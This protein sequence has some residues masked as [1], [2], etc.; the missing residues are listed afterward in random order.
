[1]K[2]ILLLIIVLLPNHSLVVPALNYSLN[3]FL[4]ARLPA[5]NYSLKD[6]LLARLPG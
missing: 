1:M 3:D 2:D 5:L 4:L 6:F